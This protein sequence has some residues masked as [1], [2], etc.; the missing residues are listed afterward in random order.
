MTLAPRTD[1]LE[2]AD[3]LFEHDALAVLE[4]YVRIPCL[5]PGFDADWE[6]NGHLRAAAELLLGWVQSQPLPGMQA[7]IVQMP[8]L[9]PV[10]VA[11]VPA[12]AGIAGAGPAGSKAGPVLLYGHLD[13][14]P[15]LGAWR[16]GLDPFV[17]VREGDALYGR[18][19]ADDGYSVFAA[20]GA[21]RSLQASG[22][23]HG[24]CIVV[25]EASE[26]SGSPHLPAY[27][28]MLAARLGPDGP[29][30]VVCLDSGCPTYDRLWTTTSLRGLL[31][32]EIR[33]EVLTEGVHSGS[34]GGVVPS[35]FRILRQ[36]L[37]RIEDEET[38]AVTLD[39]CHATVPEVRRREAAQLVATLGA[40]AAAD[41]PI[42]PGLRLGGD[43]V[44]R[45][46]ART[47]APSLAFV[48]VDGVPSVRDGGNVLRPFTAAKISM[49]LPPSADAEAAAARVAAV[50]TDDPPDGARV[51]VVT[52]G[53]QGFD[54]PVMAPWLAEAV[55]QA[56]EAYFGQPAGSA[57]EGG[58][59]PFLSALQEKYPAAQF[60]VTGVLGPESNAHG[61][62]EMLH[63]PT[64]KRVT[65]SVA[66]VLSRASS[67][68]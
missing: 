49:R 19:T 20:V 54:A 68:S 13:K 9:S 1:L 44:E 60:L 25:I 51:T 39:E 61:P 2:L 36:L 53:S 14:Q 63:L 45:V 28:E 50:L 62:N 32:A 11:D 43:P 64:A 52:E 48:G 42:V 67:A 59:I 3:H 33:V 21:L 34:A 35:S 6:T 4:G 58:T 56:S 18:G 40:G 46:L 10:I 16:D 29:S 17:P 26:E 24:R 22:L 66:H 65:A 5:S 8:G 23:A 38:G 27:L 47:W 55:E 12:S 7:E 41:F 31:L 30:L 37:S 57:G 15:P